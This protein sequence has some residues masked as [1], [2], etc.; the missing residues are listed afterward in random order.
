MGVELLSWPTRV[1]SGVAK[2]RAKY[3][4]VVNVLLVM[5]P[6]RDQDNLQLKQNKDVVSL[7]HM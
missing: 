7:L 5:S 4:G 3:S 6:Q 2:W 1:P